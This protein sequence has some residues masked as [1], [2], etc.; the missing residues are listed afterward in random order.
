MYVTR[1][2][3]DQILGDEGVIE[4]ERAAQPGQPQFMVVSPDRI[5]FTDDSEEA[6]DIYDND[7]GHRA[8]MYELEGI[9]LRRNKYT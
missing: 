7:A 9:R 5:W 1:A 4:S 8:S 6:D 3:A 2:T